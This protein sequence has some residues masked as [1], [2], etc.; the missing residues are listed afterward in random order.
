MNVT[1][2]QHKKNLGTAAELLTT[3]TEFAKDVRADEKTLKV[4][5]E[6]KKKTNEAFKVLIV[7][8][9]SSGKSSMVNAWA[10]KEFLPTGT[11]PETGVV[12][13]M[14]YGEQ[15]R[16]TLYPRQGLNN[17]QPKVLIEPTTEEIKSLC[18]IDNEAAMDEKNREKTRNLQ[19][20]RVVMECDLPLLKEGIML[21]D[22]VGMNDPWG[23]DYITE[24]YFPKADAVI[25][26]MNANMAYGS[27]DQKLL[28]K[29]NEYGLRDL[30]IVYTHYD[31]VVSANRFKPQ[32]ELEQIRRV[33]C[34]HASKHTN[35]GDQGVHF[36]DSLEGL[37]GKING[38]EKA[39]IHSGI[40]G[41]E[42]FC[43]KFLVEN[44]GAIKMRV[45]CS[46]IN[47]S[48]EKLEM[49]T[50]QLDMAANSD[51][52]H[53]EEVLKQ[54]EQE[55][56]TAESL[57]EETLSRFEKECVRTRTI[58]E[59]S[60]KAH[61][62]GLAD[63]VDLDDYTFTEELPRRWENMVFGARKKK[64]EAILTEGYQA[65]NDRMERANQEWV[66]TE[67]SELMVAQ[68]QQSIENVGQNL[69]DFY[70]KLDGLDGLLAGQQ[71][72]AKSK[73]AV[74]DVVAVVACG[75]LGGGWM[76]MAIGA[77]EG[78][79]AMGK[80][81][82]GQ[83]GVAV[84]GS[85]LV[86]LGAPITL[87]VLA[88]A[89]IAVNILQVIFQNNDK[90]LERLRTEVVKNYREGYKGEFGVQNESVKSI[91]NAYD[92]AIKQTKANLREMLNKELEEKRQNIERTRKTTL[93]NMNEK[94][95]IM[96]KNEEIRVELENVRNRSRALVA[97]Y[98]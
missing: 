18:S 47:E 98:N 79:G 97:Q 96:A 85:A 37:Y 19:Y 53:Y 44:K 60:V 52:G 80:A 65:M 70:L 38:D 87:P 13:E 59:T 12:T 74:T 77:S 15:F 23:N 81:L 93:M 83:A 28:T 82:L 11:L 61:V 10:G 3:E 32:S 86:A 43:Y 46:S 21:V 69:T 31:Q 71:Q 54:A 14:I 64:A 36:V 50:K 68:V 24:R 30:I 9:F 20:E 94:K 62:A 49:M 78:K 84:V 95:D 55:L 17:G 72:K 7:G 2:E 92:G 58:A 1:F 4:L 29:I 22:T 48:A 89:G 35:V 56:K 88:V 34:G 76:A 27:D 73:R 75:L 91:M 90:H 42:D 63:K 67:L 5:E 57:V 33:L 16:V 40:K 66:R 39:V 25:Y 26:L 6:Q 45:L 8:Q 51:T 41:L